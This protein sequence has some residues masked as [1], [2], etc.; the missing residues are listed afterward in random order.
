MVHE[1]AQE[2]S[3][4]TWFSI[5]FFHLHMFLFWLSLGDSFILGIFLGLGMVVP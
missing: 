5:I 4:E 2:I 3:F 1:L